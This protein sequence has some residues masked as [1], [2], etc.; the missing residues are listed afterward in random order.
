MNDSVN[1]KPDVP[2]AVVESAIQWRVRLEACDADAELM[3]A[4]QSWRGENPEHERAWQRLEDLDG[5]F[6]PDRIGSTWLA[7]ETLAKVDS[8]RRAMTRRNALKVLGG[9]ALGLAGM[10]MVA[11]EYGALNGINSDYSTRLGERSRFL[12][13]DGSVAWLNTNTSVAVDSDEALRSV[14]VIQGEVQL[15]VSGGDD[16]R[17]YEVSGGFGRIRLSEGTVLMRRESGRDLVELIDGS[18]RIELADRPGGLSVL[19][20]QLVAL[21]PRGGEYLDDPA[22]DYTGWVDG[23]LAV[24]DMPLARVLTELARYRPGFVQCDPALASVRVSGV[25][26]LAETDRILEA[27]ARS[28]NGTLRYRTRWWV[29]IQTA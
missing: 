12:M 15:A 14:R 17:P 2:R 7:R 9:S 25:Y 6:R 8:N 1:D 24:R 21:S 26:Q 11:N 16:P 19:P 13:N 22:M 18:A 29:G 23:V 3:A 4:C 5:L 28:V 27:L 10:A 20:G